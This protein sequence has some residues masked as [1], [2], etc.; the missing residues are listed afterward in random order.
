MR[1]LTTSN[2][3]NRMPASLDFLSRFD[4]FFGD[5]EKDFFGSDDRAL[6]QR[7]G[8]LMDFNPPVDIEESE[9]M[10]LISV[11]LPGIKTENVKV[12]VQDRTLRISGERTR[13][14]KDESTHYYE[15]SQGRFVRTFN[16][17]EAVDAKK[18]EAHSEDGVLRVLLPKTEIKTP[19]E[20]K[21]QSGKPQGLISRFLHGEKDV[22][23]PGSAATSD[24]NLKN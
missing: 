8:E 5:F 3:Q 24:K 9:G 19:Q 2:R 10:Y 14:S 20:V 23:A 1:N 22:P 12:D 17:P 13:E 15:R 6:T 4:N 16:L 7:S 21:I 18:I 11:D